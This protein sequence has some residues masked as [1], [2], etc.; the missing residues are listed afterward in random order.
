MA[1]DRQP[2]GARVTG[3]VTLSGRL[4]HAWSL[5]E[6]ARLR[7]VLPQRP[8]L[9]FAFNA[10][11]VAGFGRYAYRGGLRSVDDREIA[12]A[13]LE[14]TDAFHLAEREVATLSGGEQARVHLASAFAQ[15]WETHSAAPRFLLLDEPTAALDLAHQHQLLETA[16]EFAVARGIGVVAILHD[17]NLAAMYADRV[18]VLL[19][20]A[21]R[22]A[23]H[24]AR[25]VAAADDR[26]GFGRVASVAP[27]ARRGHVDRDGGHAMK[28]IFAALALAAL[29]C[30]AQAATRLPATADALAES[31]RG[32]RVVLLGEV[33]DN[34]VQHALRAEALRKLVQSGARPAIAFEQFDRGAQEAIDRARR[35]RPRRHRLRHRASQG[36]A[37][38]A[39]GDVQ[40]VHRA[41]AR[42]RPAD[43]GG[44]PRT[45]RRHEDGDVGNGGRRA[46]RRLLRAQEEAVR[47]G[48]CDLLPQE[49]IPGM[50]R[51][52]VARD[53]TLAQAIAPYAA[54][55]VVL[56]TGN[57]HARKDMGVAHWL[58]E[59][60]H[61]H[62]A[63]SRTT[64]TAPG[65]NTTS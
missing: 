14:L 36:R 61:Q 17:L 21:V 58:A 2:A 47:K 41:R 63:C 56:L 45:R 12:D 42:V 8:E 16:R 39:L 11:E 4:I 44:E 25:G 5:P 31:M 50:A 60:E 54:S 30:H 34:G 53:R 19:R 22:G 26:R 20:G 64:R 35:E 13:A 6:R 40:A 10:R 23:W 18:L 43:R 46:A 52:Q 7:A 38:L 3:E 27:S 29:A 9:A 33:H 48:H 1:G 59:P 37:E 55:G 32:A 62:R 49:A 51:A 24:A 57:G 28:T 65:S 15:L